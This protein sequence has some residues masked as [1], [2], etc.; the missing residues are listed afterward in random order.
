MVVFN[1]KDMGMGKDTEKAVIG[2]L[3]GMMSG[4]MSGMKEAMKE[5]SSGNYRNYTTTAALENRHYIA[6]K[7][8][9]H[10]MEVKGS[11]GRA[12]ARAVEISS[13]R[14]VFEVNDHI[15]NLSKDQAQGILAAIKMIVS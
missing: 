8:P 13:G 11:G 1:L 6:E 5:Q 7:F 3:G 2:G 9:E 4:M 14:W 10:V 12:I 15:D